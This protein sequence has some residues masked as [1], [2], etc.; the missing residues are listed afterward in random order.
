MASVLGVLSFIAQPIEYLEG[1]E[2]GVLALWVLVAAFTAAA[3]GTVLVARTTASGRPVGRSARVAQI[4]APVTLGVTLG[5]AVPLVLRSGPGPE[6]APAYGV[7][8]REAAAAV[9]GCAEPFV[10]LHR[11]VLTHPGD[12]PLHDVAVR[13]PGPQWR[14]GELIGCIRPSG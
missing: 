14:R 9:D 8:V 5:L 4:V 2:T 10:P 7:A 6:A 13:S 11:Y 1:G 3:V 12:E